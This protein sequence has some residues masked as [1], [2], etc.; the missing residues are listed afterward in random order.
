MRVFCS[1]FLF[2][3]PYQFRTFSISISISIF[4][5]LSIA[6]CQISVL[7]C[8]QKQK[9]TIYFVV[10]AH[11]QRML[12]I[13][14]CATCISRK[15]IVNH[16]RIMLVAPTQPASIWI[17]TFPIAWK[18]NKSPN[19]V[20]TNVNRRRRPSLTGCSA[21]RLSYRQI[22]MVAQLWLVIHM[23]IQCKCPWARRG[24]WMVWLWERQARSEKRL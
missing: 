18:I 20:R 22:S 9:N 14:Y 7:L 6:D 23:I 21:S 16:F 2:S 13:S 17:A 15:V 19:C 10:V 8:I 24:G 5:L 12:F 4:Q 3:R 1:F 11:I